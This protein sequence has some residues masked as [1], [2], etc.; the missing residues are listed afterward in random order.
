MSLPLDSTP[1]NSPQ[2]PSPEPSSESRPSRRRWRTI[3]LRVGAGAGT[4]AGVAGIVAVV[5]GDRILNAKVLPRVE[6]EIEKTIE[7][8]FELGEIEGFAFWGVRLGKSTMPATETDES[9]AIVD[10]VDVKV[11]LRSLIFERTLRPKIVLVRP[12][13]SLAQSAEGEWLEIGLPEPSEDDSLISVEIQTIEVQDATLTAATYEQ[14]DVVAA[15]LREPIQATQTDALISFVGEESKRVDFELSG[16]LDEGK[17]EIEGEA[18]LEKRA[19]KA[20]VRSQNLSVVGFNLLLPEGVGIKSG[21]LESSLT[22]AAALSEDRKLDQ[23]AVDVR[24]TARLQDGEVLV[25]GLA[26]PI[27]NIDSRLVFKGQQVTLEDAGLQVGDVEL[28]ASGDADWEAGYDLSATIPSITLD[29]VK[30]LAEVDIPVAVDGA[31]ALTTQVKGEIDAPRLRGQLANIQPVQVDRLG[32]DAAVADFVLTPEQFDLTRLRMTPQE[33]GTVLAEGQVDLAD[34]EN[35]SFRLTAQADLPADRFA[36]T[37]GLALPE[38][39]VVGD[40]TADVVASGTLAAP[41]ATADWQIS[42]GSFPGRGSVAF[43]DNVVVLEDA[44]WQVASGTVDAEGVLT[45]EDSAWRARAIADRLSV[46]TLARDYGVMLPGDVVAGNLSSQVEASGNLSALAASTTAFAD[47]RLSESTFPGRGTVTLA[48]SVAVLDNTRLYVADGTV[49]AEAVLQLLNGDWQATVATAGVPV[50]QFT[51]R[52]RGRLSADVDAAGNL[53][54]I[55]LEQIQARGT[56]A[57]ANAEV[58]LTNASNSLLERGLWTTAFEWQGDRIAIDA[59]SAPGVRA[60]GTIGV[61]FAQKIPIDGFDLDVALDS[62]NL[63]PLNSFA[64]ATV[65]EYAQVAGLVSFDGQLSGTLNNPRA[66]GAARLN[67]FAVNDLLFE[68]VSGP[69]ALSLAEGGRV[70]LRGEEDLIRLA[71]S[72]EPWPTSFEVRNQEFVVSGYGTDR[73][74][75]A[76]ITQFPLEKLDLRLPASSRLRSAFGEVSGMLNASLD[77]NLQDFSNPAIE[78]DLTISQPGLDPIDA[79]QL[80]ASLT[81]AN[82]TATL[83]QGELLFDDSRYLLAGS[84]NLA[85]EV[86]YEAAL[87]VAEGRIEDLAAVVERIDFSAFGIGEP[88]TAGG[89]AADLRTQSVG[90]VATNLLT[91]L[92]NFVAFVE[93]NPEE[94]ADPGRFVVPPL[95]D[96][97]G[98]FTGAIRVAGRSLA[99]EDLTANFNLQG[100]SWEWGAYSPENEFAIVGEVEE[101]T[102]ALDTVSIK[103]D[104]TAIDLTGRGSLDRLEGQLAVD[105]LPVEIVESFYDLPVSVTGNLNVATTFGGSLANPLVNGKATVANTVVSDY[106]FDRVGASFQYRDALLTAESLVAIAPDDSPITVEGT[107]P[108]ALPF[109]TVRPPTEQIAAEAVVPSDSFDFINALTDDKVRWEGGEGDVVV[110]MGGTLSNPIVD[111]QASFKGGTVSS[112]LLANGLTN[113]DGN[114]LFDLEQIDIRE[115]QASMGDGQLAV[116]GRLPFLR[117]GRSVLAQAIPVSQTRDRAETD[118]LVLSLNE[119]PVDYD[120]L[121]RADFQGQVFVTGAV[122][123]PT[124]SGGVEVD[125]GRIQANQL[126]SKAGSISLPTEEDLE[127]MSPYRVEYLGTDELNLEADKRPAGLLDS[128]ALDNFEVRFG[129][130]LAI[131][132]QPIYNLTA[133]G[134]LTV[135]GTLRDLRPDGTV[136]L[137]SGWIN[138]FSNQFRLDTNAPNTAT[139]TPETG[140]NPYVDVVMEARIQ[141]RDITPAPPKAGGFLN[142]ETEVNSGVERVG[143]IEFIEVQAVAQGPASELSDSLFLTSDSALSEGE[144]LAVLGSSTFTGLTTASYTQL[145]GFLGGGALANLGTNIADAVGL[146]SFSVFPTTDTSSESSVGIGIGVQA[147]ASIT[148]RFEVNVLEILNSQTPPQ[149]GLQYR[150]SDELD[151]RGSSNLDDTDLILEYKIEF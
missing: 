25:T 99:L 113:L 121:L 65:A 48:N 117:S 1:S 81:Y 29:E 73:Q 126:L 93:E 78:A 20:G 135:N 32:F 149:L 130:R 13:V 111:G 95:D 90:L 54:A 5:W 66:V 75:H 141:N 140:L 34:L 37:Y 110:Q 17:F 36:Q 100:D 85:G 2:P 96:L 6:A 150:F 143:E 136:V 146:R 22:V 107:L 123:E 89:S 43:A 59:F 122:L 108:Y 151:L 62:F 72:S 114:I 144:L 131:V 79:E 87:T 132:G 106:A 60:N 53:G 61:D 128:V 38:E 119:L 31:F 18:D 10:E 74:L 15:V 11:D 124:V 97:A 69:V 71:V 3:L 137:Q 68:T 120:G 138:L 103:A 12:D 8:P 116:A 26:E 9:F 112:S 105:N 92:D 14:D 4:L 21:I 24:G 77:A 134:D 91:R 19:V 58:Q 139:F 127:E 88:P 86:Q 42:N 102:F 80:T 46:D 63:S 57:I 129:D 33:G 49:D 47:W 76:D 67:N 125:N 40:L 64:P 30:R 109:M 133:L 50:E 148:D 28:I 52:A 104:D 84:A 44:R 98:E 51:D 7:R 82:S 27:V 145:A 55:N 118:G 94:V 115:L 35:L 56:A 39:I 147:T 41:R 23:S 45:L 142:A 70:N 16:N 101:M 83:T